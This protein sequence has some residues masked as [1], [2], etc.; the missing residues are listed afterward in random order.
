M[1]FTA[2]QV[3]SAIKDS[4]ESDFGCNTCGGTGDQIA[5]LRA[6]ADR[7]DQ[8]EQPIPVTHIVPNEPSPGT[9]EASAVGVS[10]P[11]EIMSR[12]AFE[13]RYPKFR[14]AVAVDHQSGISLRMVREYDAAKD[15][16]PTPVEVGQA[17]VIKAPDGQYLGRLNS[18]AV[19]VPV[20]LTVEQ[21]VY[22]RKCFECGYEVTDAGPGAME[23]VDESWAAHEL[24][25]G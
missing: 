19:F 11:T 6:Y 13:A 23:R 2:Q 14:A 20:E 8:D 4:P 22:S 3:R 17:W 25:H 12:E 16:F 9:I 15:Q 7:L 1:T 5:M 18:E 21:G 10:F 24:T